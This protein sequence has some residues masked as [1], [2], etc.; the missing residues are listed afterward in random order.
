VQASTQSIQI[1]SIKLNTQV[2]VA[3]G[4]MAQNAL[5]MDSNPINQGS[6]LCSDGNA[7]IAGH[8]SPTKR[9]QKAGKVFA[10]LYKVKIGEIVT[11]PNCSYKIKSITT[12]KG[13]VNRDGISYHYSDEQGNFVLENTFKDGTLTLQTCT[14][15]LGEILILKGEKI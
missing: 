4:T 1:D 11:A 8:N 13:T 9:N 5:K 12:L 2:V 6:D 15:N 7:Y 3:K 10:N 14:R